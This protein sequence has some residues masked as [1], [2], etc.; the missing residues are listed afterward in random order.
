[1]ASSSATC[2]ASSRVGRTMSA[3]GDPD[4]GSSSQPSSPGPRVSMSR[5]RAKPSVFPVPVLAWPMMSWPSRATGSASAWMGKG[6]VTPC[7]ARA[8][9]SSGSTPR[10]AKVLPVR[11]A[12]PSS[13]VISGVA[14]SRT[15]AWA[16]EVR[17]TPEASGASSG[18][19]PFRGARAVCAMGAPSALGA[20]VLSSVTT[21][22]PVGPRV[23][24]ARTGAV[25]PR[26]AGGARHGGAGRCWARA[27]RAELLA[28]AVR[29]PIVNRVPHRA[30]GP[31]GPGCGTT[32]Q[33]WTPPG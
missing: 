29:Q 21:F 3:C 13:S 24:P 9:Q 28:V 18:T 6:W 4:A 17:R 2:L 5:G 11:S 16:P 7:S 25:G 26:P 30:G 12:S 23:L 33:P 10:S 1:M 15:G 22:L 8:L 20:A 32:G 19:G 31:A 27:R 14:S